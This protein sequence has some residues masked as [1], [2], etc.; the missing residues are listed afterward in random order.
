MSRQMPESGDLYRVQL[1]R[2]VTEDR[3]GRDRWGDRL[4]EATDEVHYT[5]YEGPYGTIGA[6][7]ARLTHQTN[8]GYRPFHSGK[9]QVVKNP[10]WEDVE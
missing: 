4:I 1:N 9:V 7:R 10:K 3:G 8:G 5:R 6:A 2:H